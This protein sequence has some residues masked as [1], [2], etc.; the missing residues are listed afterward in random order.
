[1]LGIIFAQML[2]WGVV[3]PIVCICDY[4]MIRLEEIDGLPEIILHN[5]QDQQQT[6]NMNIS[7]FQCHLDTQQQVAIQRPN[8]A[9]IDV[10]DHLSQPLAHRHTQD[11]SECAICCIVFTTNPVDNDGESDG[12]ESRVTK[13]PCD[14]SHFFH[15]ACIKQWARQKLFC[16]L[17]NKA[18]NFNSLRNMQVRT[19][20]E[21]AAAAIAS[22]GSNLLDVSS[23]TTQSNF[24]AGNEITTEMGRMQIINHI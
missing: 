7:E 8:H 10:L 13:L 22:R 15:T 23:Y 3:M 18:F 17:C 12:V 11:Q 16:P 19:V 24:Y 2:F 1:M 9:I 20:E 14:P 6:T 21:A 4:R 5:P